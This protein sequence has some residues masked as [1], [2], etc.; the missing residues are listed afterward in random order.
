MVYLDQNATVPVLPEVVEA[1]LPWLADKWGNPSSSYRFGQEG[2]KAVEKARDQVASL[3]GADPSQVIFTSGATEA[4][5]AALHSSVVRDP[6][7]RHVITSSVEHSSVLSYC[8]YLE[9]WHGVVV[10]YLP[11]DSQGKLDLDHLR[12]AIRADTA[13]V[14][15]MWANNETGAI[16]PICKIAAVCEQHGVRLHTDAVQAVGKTGVS[17][18]L[19]GT[20]YLSLSGHKIGAPKGIGA[21]VV[22]DPDKFIP[23]LYGGTQE[24]NRRGGTESVPLIVGMGEAA[25][26]SSCRGLDCW[27]S[28]ERL[29]DLFE[30]ELCDRIPGAVVNGGGSPRLPNTSNIHLPGVDADGA[31]TFLDQRGIC[32]SSGSACME[33]AISPSHVIQAMTGSHE[34]ASESLRI[35]LGLN[36]TPK[37]L[38]ELLVGLEAFA[39]VVA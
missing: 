36:T 30:D 23:L 8:N 14:S 19:I 37:D 31:V 39:A 4:N 10:T 34:R 27:V 22:S 5:N 26:C 2:R 28:A 29:R 18:A 35:S 16:N 13:I 11:V 1:M 15:L 32:V 33:S 7:R 17:F 6:K 12:E 21:L 3:I 9:R 38:Q 20:Q 25:A 24:Q